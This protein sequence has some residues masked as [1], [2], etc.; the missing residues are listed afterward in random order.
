MSVKKKK[1]CLKYQNWTFINE[2]S[3]STHC[4]E[5]GWSKW[6]DFTAYNLFF[7]QKKQWLTHLRLNHGLCAELLDHKYEHKSP[8]SPPPPKILLCNTY[9]FSIHWLTVQK[10]FFFFS[11]TLHTSRQ[12]NKHCCCCTPLLDLLSATEHT[13]SNREITGDLVSKAKPW[14][15]VRIAMLQD[16]PSVKS[17]L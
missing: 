12:K 17:Q 10:Q 9:S 6:T 11:N 7:K 16:I 5:K 1:N 3:F 13:S 4:T 2:C 14:L 15:Y 8:S